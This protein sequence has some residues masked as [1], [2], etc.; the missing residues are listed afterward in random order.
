M[1]THLSAS[2]AFAAAAALG[3]TQLR[4]RL[5][6]RRTEHRMRQL[7]GV[8]P[9]DTAVRTSKKFSI[10]HPLRERQQRK[11][12]ALL[13][14]QLAPAI[15]LIVGHLRIG[16]NI[17]AAITEVSDSLSE[18]L[19]SVFVDAVEEARLGT[20]IS[21]S[22]QQAAA[23]EGNRHL[24]VVASAIGLQAKHGGSLVEI[25]EAVH[26]TIEEEDR[27][28]RD[29]QTLTADNRISAK[30]LLALPP[31]TLVVVSLFN[32]GYASPLITDPLGQRMTAFGVVLA[33]IGWRWLRHLSNP[34]VVA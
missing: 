28:R 11:R 10:P 15:E 16:R 20:P 7:A 29:I 34:E 26:T 6:E 33:L 22:L 4:T 3:I 24:G 1:S 19:R 30:V 17:G 9:M 23:E 32:P 21:D 25:L 14:S 27:L 5:E 12:N 18:P 13:S 8:A 2:F 31:I